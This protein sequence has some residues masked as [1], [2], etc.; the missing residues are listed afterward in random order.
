MRKRFFYNNFYETLS[1]VEIIMVILLLGVLHIYVITIVYQ[2]SREQ[3]CMGANS[4]PGAKSPRSPLS[5]INGI[6]VWKL[7]N[8]VT[9]LIKQI[10]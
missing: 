10:N 4:P 8:V 9:T 6:V 3:K 1:F 7:E 2:Q 5:E